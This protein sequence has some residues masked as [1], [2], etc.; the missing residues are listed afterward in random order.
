MFWRKPMTQVIGLADLPD[1]F[2]QP[3]RDPSYQD[4][5]SILRN[6]HKVILYIVTTM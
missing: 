4:L 6:P 5:T 3:F 1:Q 2:S